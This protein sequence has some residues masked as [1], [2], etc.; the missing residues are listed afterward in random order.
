[1]NITNVNTTR[2]RT[3][4][5]LLEFSDLALPFKPRAATINSVYPWEQTN[6]RMLLQQLYQLAAD[7]GFTGTE[8][9]FKTQFGNYLSRDQK[10]VIF[11]MYTNFPLQGDTTKLYFDLTDNILYYWD[12]TDGYI[13][14]NAMLIANTI[15]EGGEA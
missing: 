13:P 15:L 11:D 4:D 1:M 8:E 10:E 14:V 5:L 6:Y 12:A 7:T 3:R 9:Q 2:F